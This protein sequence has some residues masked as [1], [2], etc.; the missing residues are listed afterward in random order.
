MSYIRIAVYT[1]PSGTVQEVA[2]LA[3]KGMANVFRAQPGFK[4]YG[5]TQNQ[6]GKLVSV[7]LWESYEQAQR[8][9]ELAVSWEEENLAG[10]IRLENTYVGDFTLDESS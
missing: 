8:A 10:N 5:L 7:S 6:E 9:N 3:R 2:D 1:F 4:A